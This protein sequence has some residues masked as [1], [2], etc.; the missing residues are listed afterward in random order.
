MTSHWWNPGRPGSRQ[1]VIQPPRL[2]DTCLTVL[3]A[4]I[5]L[6][7]TVGGSNASGAIGPGPGVAGPTWLLFAA[8]HLP[9]IWRRRAPVTVF[10]SVLALVGLCVV[11]NVPGVYLVFAPLFALYGVARY[12]R[13]I[14]LWPALAAVLSAVV[15]ATLTSSGQLSTL[16]GIGSIVAATCLLAISLRLREKA[17]RERARH[18]QQELDA[19]A[20]IAVVAERTQLAREVHDVVAHNLAVMVALADGAAATAGSDPEQA[21]ELMRQS[22]IT[23]RAALSEMRRMV[24]VLRDGHSRAPQPGLGDLDEL[25]AQVRD[26]GLQVELSVVGEHE[27]ALSPGA[28][29]IIYRIVQEALTNT[30]KHAGPKARAEVRLLRTPDSVDLTITDDGAGAPPR[31]TTPG[32]HGLLGITERATTYGGTIRSGP[33]TPTGWHLTAHLPHTP[34]PPALPSPQPD[35]SSEKAVRA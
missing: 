14:Q 21:T 26:A 10:W 34:D 4:L 29:V 9:L 19:R 17:D 11:L 25:V 28:G 8:V 2:V 24:G 16:I 5:V 6:P 23:G 35:L 31:P 32:G 12:A 15:V 22:S 1:W 13:M 3:L 27:E 18:L 30:L 20:R 33:T 7:A